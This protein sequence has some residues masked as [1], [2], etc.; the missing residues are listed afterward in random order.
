P[1]LMQISTYGKALFLIRQD[2]LAI[3]DNLPG[4]VN[5]HPGKISH[6]Q[7]I[8]FPGR[9]K[10]L[11]RKNPPNQFVACDLLE[12]INRIGDLQSLL[13]Q[14]RTSLEASFQGTPRQKCM[15]TEYAE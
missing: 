8:Q 9:V 11:Q 7:R 13:V 14:Y 6:Y 4:P 2:K 15:S 5:A 10:V 1:G 3:R 12:H